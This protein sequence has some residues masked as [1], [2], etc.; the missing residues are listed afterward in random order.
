MK[1]VAIKEERHIIS[2]TDEDLKYI[3][4]KE[5]KR[6]I[7]VENY[8]FQEEKLQVT[9]SSLSSSGRGLL[10][11]VVLINPTN[12]GNMDTSKQI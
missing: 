7:D 10:I 11:D 8:T 5:A 3:L 12:N 6:L 9:S 4:I 2:F 1:Y